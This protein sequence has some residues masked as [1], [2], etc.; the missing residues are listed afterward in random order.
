MQG[1]ESYVSGLELLLH[2]PDDLSS[3]PGKKLEPRVEGENLQ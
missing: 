1:T 3:V 2:K